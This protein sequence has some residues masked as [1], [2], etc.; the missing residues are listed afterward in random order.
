MRE[1][2]EQGRGHLGV[3]DDGGTF[4]EGEI[5][6]DHD[7]GALVELADQMEQQLATCLCEGQMTEEEA[8]GYEAKLARLDAID[9]ECM[10]YD[11]DEKALASIRLS[12]DRNGKIAVRS[13]LL[14]PAE[15]HELAQRRRE[16]EQA[17][18]E[19]EAEARGEAYTPLEPNN[20]PP[21][22]TKTLSGRGAF[23]FVGA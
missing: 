6:G 21:P 16:R 19:A 5:G 8:S 1:A 12:V 15:Q 14:K 20:H 11:P 7:G 22:W 13:G 9:A 2:I 18:R 17:E 23:T 3:S 10:G 4:F